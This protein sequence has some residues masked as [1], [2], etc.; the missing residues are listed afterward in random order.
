VGGMKG[1]RIALAVKFN[2]GKA[3]DKRLFKIESAQRAEEQIEST[4]TGNPIADSI[5]ANKIWNDHLK[6]IK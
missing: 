5:T 2:S 1:N 4:R 3:L 6:R